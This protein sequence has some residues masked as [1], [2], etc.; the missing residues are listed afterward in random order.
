[1]LS[2]DVE[3]IDLRTSERTPE[4]GLIRTKNVTSNQDG[5]TVMEMETVIFVPR[6]PAA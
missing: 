2:L 3:I 4:R 1:V 5:E 6:R